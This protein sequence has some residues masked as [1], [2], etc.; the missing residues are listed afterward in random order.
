MH[1]KKLAIK[2]TYP[3]VQGREEIKIMEFTAQEEIQIQPPV[4]SLSFA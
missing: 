2:T 1:I 3:Y 4:L